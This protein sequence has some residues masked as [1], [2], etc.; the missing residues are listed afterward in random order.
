MNEDRLFDLPDLPAPKRNYKVK[1]PRAATVSK[2]KKSQE[3]AH[4]RIVEVFDFWVSTFKKKRAVLDEKR[5]QAIGAAIHDY[6]TEACKNAIIGCSLSDYY[7]GR[8]KRGRVYNDIE[9]ILRDSDHIEKFLATY[10]KSQSR[11]DTDW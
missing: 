2:N 3:V 8:N 7:M 10:D 9:L 6:G 4:E 1:R 5:R 11:N